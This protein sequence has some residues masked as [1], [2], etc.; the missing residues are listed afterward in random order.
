MCRAPKHCLICF[1]NSTK[2]WHTKGMMKCF[3]HDHC[4]SV[5][6]FLGGLFVWRVFFL[7]RLLNFPCLLK[8]ICEPGKKIYLVITL[9]HGKKVH[10]FASYWAKT[11]N[12]EALSTAANLPTA[13]KAVTTGAELSLTSSVVKGKLSFHIILWILLNSTAGKRISS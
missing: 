12:S 4:F 7:L 9:K 3:Q 5:L 10:K 11:R 1:W 2:S 6:F 13:D 8:N